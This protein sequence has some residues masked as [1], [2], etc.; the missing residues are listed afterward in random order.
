MPFQIKARRKKPNKNEKKHKKKKCT[1]PAVV[2]FKVSI[3][4]HARASLVLS[5][6]KHTLLLQRG[7]IEDVVVNKEYRGKQLGKLY[8]HALALQQG[9]KTICDVVAKPH[10]K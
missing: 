8:V 1:R 6:L 7:R 4:T 9:E 10:I 5:E 3:V 2:S